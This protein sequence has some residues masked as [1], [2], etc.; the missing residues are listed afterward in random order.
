M[1]AE[2]PREATLQHVKHDQKTVVSLELLT[3][4]VQPS[5]SMTS[6]QRSGGILLGSLDDYHGQVVRPRSTSSSFVQ[7]SQTRSYVYL[8][9]LAATSLL[10]MILL[11]VAAN[12]AAPGPVTAP[13]PAPVSAR[14]LVP[15][16]Q[17]LD[18]VG[19]VGYK[20]SKPAVTVIFPAPAPAP[21]AKAPQKQQAGSLAAGPTPGP[22][23]AAKK[24]TPAPVPTKTV[25][26]EKKTGSLLGMAP[27]PGPAAGKVSKAGRKMGAP[28]QAPGPAH[29]P[30]PAKSVA[31]KRAARTGKVAGAPAFA[32]APGLGG[33][34]AAFRPTPAPK[35]SRSKRGDLSEKPVS[36]FSVGESVAPAA[37][38]VAA[39]SRAPAK[40]AAAAVAP[41]AAP[42]PAR[43]ASAPGPARAASAPSGQPGS[44]FKTLGS[45]FG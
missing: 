9:L 40:R 11:M 8:R 32:P 37:A 1:L 5:P 24:A 26:K 12:I 4:G 13:A 38:P 14:K 27:A 23:K 2:F 44:G 45:I 28:A 17:A 10:G 16:S 21:S 36:S 20:P 43:K 39:P 25:N 31:V 22:A 42:G 33:V 6:R 41:A 34:A 19:T 7:D 30:V 18:V 35:A 15:T 29:A 3:P